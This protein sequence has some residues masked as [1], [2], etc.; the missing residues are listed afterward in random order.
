MKFN[1]DFIGLSTTNKIGFSTDL[2]FFTDQSTGSNHKIEKITDDVI[3]KA[4]KTAA[5]L[6]ADDQHLLVEG[7]D[8]KLN[9][10]PNKTEEFLLSLIHI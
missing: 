2:I 10:S 5:T 8:F 9:I 3:G 7:N 1:N 6:V 4:I